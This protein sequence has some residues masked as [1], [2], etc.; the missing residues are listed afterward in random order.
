MILQAF[1]QVT[2]DEAL[3]ED[4]S[5]NFA[6]H[7]PSGTVLQDWEPS[8]PHRSWFNDPEFRSRYPEN[9]IDWSEIYK[10]GAIESVAIWG[11]TGY[12]HRNEL[13]L[14]NLENNVPDEIPFA[15]CWTSPSMR[16]KLFSISTILRSLGMPVGTVVY[17]GYYD[18]L[19]W[20][21]EPF[22]ISS[23]I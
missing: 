21:F 2:M 22:F 1:T 17:P 18:S 7:I 11:R 14:D 19:L 5:L 10:T 9:S 4:E 20:R 23:V 13:L 16:V 15:C 8:R 3:D 6:W 12:F